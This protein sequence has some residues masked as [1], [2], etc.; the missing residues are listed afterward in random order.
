MPESCLVLLK[1]QNLTGAQSNPTMSMDGT[2]ESAVDHLRVED[3][4]DQFEVLFGAEGVNRLHP[5]IIL[6]I[7]LYYVINAKLR[8]R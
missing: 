6:W 2:S 1:N 3:R 8:G 7:P 5:S 4:L